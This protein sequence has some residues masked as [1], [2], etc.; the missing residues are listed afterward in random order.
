MSEKKDLEYSPSSGE[1]GGMT[2]Q[3]DAATEVLY[4]DSD[5]FGQEEGHD[6]CF[7]RLYVLSQFSNSNQEKERSFLSR[8]QYRPL[9][10]MI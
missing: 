1:E 10:Q 2:L 3:G 5:V 8:I 4:H 9:L 6:V 7:D